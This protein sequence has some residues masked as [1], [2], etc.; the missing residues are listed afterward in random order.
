MELTSAPT[1]IKLADQ[2]KDLAQQKRMMVQMAVISQVYL[3][4]MGLE[5][6][7]QL[8]RRSADIDQVDSKISKMTADKEKE[9]AASQAEK[10]AADASAII[11]KLRK[12]QALSQLFAASGKMQATAGLEPDINSLHETTLQD[13]TGVIKSSFD[14]WNS[15]KLPPLTVATAPDQTASTG[16]INEGEA[17]K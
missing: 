6:S 1:A 11:S 2:N 7:L 5:S 9:G 16:N 17:S 3:A 13:L 10:V 14:R 12:Y 8:Y 4:K 15:G